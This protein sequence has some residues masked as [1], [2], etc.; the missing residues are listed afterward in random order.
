[1]VPQNT[2]NVLTGWVN[3][4]FLR[5]AP[6]HGA[7]YPYTRIRVCNAVR[8]C[9]NSYKGVCRL[10]KSWTMNLDVMFSFY[11]IPLPSWPVKHGTRWWNSA[12]WS[13]I[14]LGHLIRAICTLMRCHEV[15]KR[16]ADKVLLRKGF[17]Q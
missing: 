6:F 9:G 13:T 3:L 4:G 17:L 5:R 14:I 1:M 2:G 16:D 8:E 10:F 15:E 7:R 11:V 12:S